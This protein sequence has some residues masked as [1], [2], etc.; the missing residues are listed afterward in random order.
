[1]AASGA[2]IPLF[3]PEPSP[4]FDLAGEIERLI[5]DITRVCR[6]F[7]HID[8][9]RLLVGWTSSRKRRFGVYATIYPLRFARG[10]TSISSRGALWHLPRVLRDGREVDYVITF[11][12]PR[13]LALDPPSRLAVVFHELFHVSAACDGDLRRF[14]GHRSAHGRSVKAFEAGFQADLA[15]Y[16]ASRRALHFHEIL[17]LSHGEILRRYGAVVPRRVRRPVLERRRST[18]HYESGANPG[19]GLILVR[20]RATEIA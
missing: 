9:G 7:S 6:G 4:G 17:S 18:W 15:V 16:M 12:V 10:R 20:A 11:Y 3:A 2:Q 5:S 19:S 14:E 13:F 1:M 8:P